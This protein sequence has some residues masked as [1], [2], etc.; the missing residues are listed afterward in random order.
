MV[1]PLGRFRRCG[2][3]VGLGAA[4]LALGGEARAQAPAQAGTQPPQAVNDPV[5]RTGPDWDGADWSPKPPVLPLSPADQQ[6]RFI[7]QPG[8]SLTPVLTDPQIKQPGAIAFDANGR[9]YVLELRSYM[10]DADAT[11]ELAPISRI[12]RWEDRDNDGTYEHGTVFVDSLVFPRFVTPLTD[13]VILTKESNTD[14]V[15]KYTDTNGD[16]KADRRELF[17]TGFGRSGNVEHQEAFLTLAMDN[18]LYSTVNSFRLRITPN[19]VVREP[20]GNNGAQWGITQDDYGK[21]WFDS[22]SGGTPSYFQF[23]IV[24]GRFN[25]PEQF[26]EGFRVPYGAAVLVA[27]MQGGMDQVKWPE[28]NLSQVTGSAGNEIFRGHRLPAELR[29]DYFYGE[30][31]ARVVRR[32]DP[33]TTEGLTQLHNVYQPQQAEFIRSTDPLFRPVD[34]A[35]A[36]DGT[37]YVVDMYHGIIQEAQWAQRGTYLRARIEQYQLDKVIDR[38]RIWRL[39]YQGMERDRTEP[40]MYQETAAQLLRHL[41]HPNGWWRDMAQQQLVLRQDRSVA[42][43]LRTMARSNGNQLAR[44]HA[45]WT[46]E[47]LG[48]LD[49]ALARELM[50]DPDPKIRTTAIRASETLYKGG[51]RSLA[52]DYRAAAADRDPEVAI[53]GVLTLNTLRAPDA[54][55]AIEAARAANPAAGVQLVASTIL[56]PPATTGGGGGGGG[57]AQRTP[58]ETALLTRGATLFQETC[59]ECHGDTGLGRDIGNGQLMAPVLAGNPRVL[60]HPDHVIKVLL[61]G[62]TGAIEGR[63]YAG[64]IMIPMGATQNDE[65]VAAVSSYIRTSLGSTGSMVTPQQVA[66]VRAANAGRTTPWTHAALLASVPQPLAVQPT[67][68]VT[69]SHSVPTRIGMTGSPAGAFNFEGWSSGGTQAPGMWFQV[70]LPQATRLTEVTFVSPNQRRGGGGGGQAALPPAIT[71]PREYQVQLS[72]DGTNWTIVT[73]G[74]GESSNVTMSFTPTQARFL[75]INQTGSGEEN[76]PWQMQEMRLFAVQ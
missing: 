8:Y 11:N 40:R 47:G 69:A 37:M 76:V 52:A 42:P 15:W 10:L 50:R 46:L 28:G 71:A 68:R 73:T 29:T 26:A 4:L 14:E 21:L 63:E 64:G 24:Y 44:V 9:M 6:R 57:G 54:R 56:T 43:A 72:N 36:P 74:R 5:N 30:A 16:G 27:D 70:E 18:W 58:A 3:A 20:T 17:T 59:T 33:V 13:G 31:V 12:S 66:A 51:D 48:A 53:Q 34:V 45:V 62:M 32:V 60:G 1:R 22:G 7:L 55:T 39:T 75:R 19:G 65:W 38:G 67:W 2:L 49:A 41:E 35:T 61:H 23:P 25:Y